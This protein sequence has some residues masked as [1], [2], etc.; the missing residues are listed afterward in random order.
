MASIFFFQLIN[1]HRLSTRDHPKEQTCQQDTKYKIQVAKN[2]NK[3]S[4]NQGLLSRKITVKNLLPD[5]L[6]KEKNTSKKLQKNKKK[7]LCNELFRK[8]QIFLPKI[9]TQKREVQ[10]RGSMT[11]NRFKPN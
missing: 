3:E 8:Q 5:E 1:L 2:K 6:K 11:K 4:D 9:K 7:K 10:V